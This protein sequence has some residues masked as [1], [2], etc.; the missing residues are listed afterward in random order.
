MSPH[1]TKNYCL[2]G[3]ASGWGATNTGTYLGPRKIMNSQDPSQVDT[4]NITPKTFIDYFDK[5]I[6]I[7]S[8]ISPPLDFFPLSGSDLLIRNAQCTKVSS[9]LYKAV[10]SIFEEHAFPFVLGGDQSISIGTWSSVLDYTHKKDKTKPLGLIWIDAHLDAHTPETSESKALHGMAAAVLMGAGIKSLSP[11]LLEPDRLVYI[12]T[13]SYEEGELAFL[14]SLGI[15]IYYQPEVDQRGFETVFQEAREY[16]TREGCPYG[17]TFDIDAFDPSEAPGTGARAPNGLK[18][19]EVLPAIRGL[20]SDTNLV[21]FEMVE[22]NP[23]LDQQ[24]KT[25]NLIW[26]LFHEMIHA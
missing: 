10:G 3:V 24:D 23:K 1:L 13:R 4:I 12:G 6:F 17:I 2:I 22:F 21:A 19:R 15:K 7:E 11:V 18:S 25:L 16:V 8:E 5:S 26:K 9:E 20:L 14:K